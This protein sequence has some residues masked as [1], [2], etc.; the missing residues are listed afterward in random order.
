MSLLDVRLKL[1]KPDIEINPDDD[2]T[3]NVSKK[4]ITYIYEEPYGSIKTTV[5][6]FEDGGEFGAAIICRNSPDYSDELLGIYSHS[7][8]ADVI[9]RLGAP[10][11]ISI[12]ADGLAKMLSFK[13]YKVG[14]EIEKNE[15]SDMCATGSGTLRY[16][17]E[18]GAP[19]ES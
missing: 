12:R 17:Q 8:E 7:T 13:K 11:L 18:Y 10:S 15:I 9:K 2:Q 4:A 5:R 16:I 6:F 19:P 14:F 1:G 3:A